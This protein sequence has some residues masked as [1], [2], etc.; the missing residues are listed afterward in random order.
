MREDLHGDVKPTAFTRRLPVS[1]AVEKFSD[2]YPAA[3]DLLKLHYAEIAPMKD[4]FR[5]NPDLITYRKLELMGILY[6]ITARDDGRLVGY[7]SLI[8]KEHLHY[9]DVLMATDDIHFL[10][11]D[12]RHGR[13]GIEMLLF[14]E[15]QMKTLGVKVMALRAKK[16]SGHDPLYERLLG[17]E[18]MDVVYLKRLD[19]EP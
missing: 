11:P 17:Y 1:F 19:K 16:A 18:A 9:K 15:K 8:V 2:V 3:L 13:V 12:Y 4:L 14:A 7:V 10:H 6:I 5:L